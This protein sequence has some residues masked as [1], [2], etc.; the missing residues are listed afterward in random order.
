MI[1]LFE[2]YVLKKKKSNHVLFVFSLWLCD[3]QVCHQ[4]IKYLPST[5]ITFLFSCR[6][7]H[8]N[9]SDI[10]L[11]L[12]VVTMSNFIGGLQELDMALYML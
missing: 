11:L 1:R 2:G 5:S 7:F 4:K 9:L 3:V 12:R 10:S 6:K 8:D